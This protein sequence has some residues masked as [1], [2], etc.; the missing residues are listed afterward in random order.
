M[1]PS[2]SILIEPLKAG[3]EAAPKALVMIIDRVLLL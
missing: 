2:I 1:S 3:D